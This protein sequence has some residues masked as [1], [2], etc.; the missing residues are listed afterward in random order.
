VTVRRPSTPPPALA[1]GRGAAVSLSSAP[2]PLSGAESRGAC[3][4]SPSSFS[5]L[6]GLAD[7]L[8]PKERRYAQ[9]R[10][11]PQQP[12][13]PASLPPGGSGRPCGNS[14]VRSGDAISDPGP[15]AAQQGA[16]AERSAG[17]TA[18]GYSFPATRATNSATWNAS[19]PWTMLA[20][21]VP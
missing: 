13:S 19:L 11:W 10:D 7:G 1:R 17:E 6:A 14:A 15:L 8:A 3:G 21:I 2:A 18:S 20:G 4:I 9:T 5:V 12:G 16:A